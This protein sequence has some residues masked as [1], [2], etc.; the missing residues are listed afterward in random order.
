MRV[1]EGLGGVPDPV[2][3][4]ELVVLDFTAYILVWFGFLGEEL[5]A[6]L[7]L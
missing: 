4:Q 6:E 5:A 2:S 7:I 3:N 1:L